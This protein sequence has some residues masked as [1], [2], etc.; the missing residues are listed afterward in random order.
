MLVLILA[1]FIL[2]G[3]VKVKG[4]NHKGHPSASLRAGSGTQRK[5]DLAGE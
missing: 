5:A 3:Q 4:F 1:D 2:L